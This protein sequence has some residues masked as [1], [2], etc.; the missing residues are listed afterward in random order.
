MK[1]IY[2]FCS[3]L[4][5]LLL[6]SCKDYDDSDIQNK[7]NEFHERITAL[8]TKADK[9]N[10]DI[11]KL[12]YLTEGNV[13]TSV[14][15][16]ADGQYVITYKDSKNEEKAVIVATQEDVI[17]APILG[18]RLN[19][20]DQ[21][22]YWTTTIDNETDWLT[23]DAGKKVPVSGYTPE[24]GVNADGQWTVNGKV[25]KDGNGNPITATTDETAIFKK[26][27]KTDDGY[28]EITL[29]NGETFTL[30]V[31]NSLNLKLKADAVTTIDDPTKPLSIEYE[32][33]GSSAGNAIVSI[34]QATG[35]KATLD[36]E[37]RI[38]TV[39]F[40]TGFSEGQVIITAY[41][42]K[43]LVLRPLLFK[44]N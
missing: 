9:L 19:E 32:V 35:V 41:D 38:L 25:L 10:E 39:T 11:S 29:G 8:Q 13:I 15:K 31:F 44:K 5:S 43:H 4:L 33:T 2:I 1:R 17:E 24:M 14:A 18:V 37:T 16:N 36:Q 40:D 3:V 30:E 34:A 28:L 27:A 23:D 42:L 7:L 26:I 21:L 20:D 12:G 22:Y 6:G